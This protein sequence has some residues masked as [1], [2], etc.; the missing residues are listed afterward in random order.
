MNDQVERA[1]IAYETF[2]SGLKDK[3]TVP[4]WDSSPGWVRDAVLVAYL[5]GQLDAPQ[6]S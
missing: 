5:Q 6:R 4:D 1:K 2:L 3:R